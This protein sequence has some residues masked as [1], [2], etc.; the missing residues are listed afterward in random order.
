[1]T[2]LVRKNLAIARLVARIP[3]HP[4]SGP[5]FGPVSGKKTILVNILASRAPDLRARLCIEFG[6]AGQL[7]MPKEE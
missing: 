7:R 3:D 2:L 5:V 4:V 6:K 1:M